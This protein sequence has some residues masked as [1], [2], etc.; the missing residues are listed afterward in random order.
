MLQYVSYERPALSK[1]Y[2]FPENPARLPGFQTCVGGG[3]ERQPPEWYAENGEHF[4]RLSPVAWH[5]SLIN[6][7]GAPHLL[8]PAPCHLSSHTPQKQALNRSPHPHPRDTRPLPPIP[9]STGTEFLTSRRLVPA[10]CCP[11]PQALT[12]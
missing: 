9:A 6:K 2:L 11:F 12:S 5:L 1:A 10:A 3:G 4:S 7:H 8:P